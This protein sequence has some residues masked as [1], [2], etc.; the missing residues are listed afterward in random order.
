MFLLFF[1][2][3]FH[4]LLP[5]LLLQG[6]SKIKFL[7]QLL[8]LLR[9]LRVCFIIVKV[10]ADVEHSVVA[11][12]H[13]LSCSVCSVDCCATF[14]TALINLLKLL[15]VFSTNC[16]TVCGR[17]SSARS[18]SYRERFSRIGY[19]RHTFLLCDEKYSHTI[20]SINYRAESFI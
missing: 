5:S 12:V 3:G 8:P 13:I 14:F 18:V 11:Y 19:A 10:V 1:S 20:C 4:V 2:S 17:V 15:C 9:T 7:P 6:R 16:G